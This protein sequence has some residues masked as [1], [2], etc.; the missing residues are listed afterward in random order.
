M[1]AISRPGKPYHAN[2]IAGS[3]LHVGHEFL[4][5]N[6]TK[7][8]SEWYKCSHDNCF[9]G[10]SLEKFSWQIEQMRSS[11]FS[12]FSSKPSTAIWRI[13]AASS[14][15]FVEVIMSLVIEISI[16]SSLKT[17]LY[18]LFSRCYWISCHVN[19]EWSSLSSRRFCQDGK[20]SPANSGSSCCRCPLPHRLA[21]C[22]HQTMSAA[23]ELME[24]VRMLVKPWHHACIHV[25]VIG[26]M[27]S[28]PPS[29]PH[30][31]WSAFTK[32]WQPAM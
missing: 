17:K 15:W 14:S 22:Q 3:F 19:A 10:C 21:W 30:S 24:H 20:S 31:R 23:A 9:A 7:M 13:L 4:K 12:V 25:M 32:K 8:H 2:T 6:H 28:P 11:L 5:Q 26:M 27:D 16:L 29:R 18:V 1:E